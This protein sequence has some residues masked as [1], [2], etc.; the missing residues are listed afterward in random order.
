MTD[1]KPNLG[2]LDSSR[3]TRK[4]GAGL[5]LRPI[6]AHG[7]FPTG[8]GLWMGMLCALSLL[9]LRGAVLEQLVLD[10]D[11]D[12]VLPILSPPLGGLT[13]LMLAGA[14]GVVGA[15][16]GYALGR[17]LQRQGRAGARAEK[18]MSRTAEPAKSAKSAEP[19][20]RFAAM[21]A[22]MASL[23]T[24][25]VS[26]DGH[27]DAPA[28]AP[29]RAHEELGLSLGPVTAPAAAPVY[30]PASVYD[31]E[32]AHD[33]APAYDHAP[34]HQDVAHQQAPLVLDAADEYAAPEPSL[35]PVAEESAGAHPRL[36][37]APLAPP[38]SG[39]SAAQRIASAPVGDLNNVELVSRLAA[40]MDRHRLPA[41]EHSDAPPPPQQPAAMPGADAKSDLLDDA[42]AGLRA[43]G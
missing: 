13:R 4:A 2:L 42:L 11:L 20:G 17:A 37:P 12:S 7:L 27:P 16:L 8:T 25:L 41:G 18:P 33:H 30:D 31:H 14:L 38:T 10:Y 40:L 24:P 19:S 22:V 26:R 1:R 39:P 35:P 3:T 28:R 9:A 15:G 6:V 21:R 34:A 36:A 32:S 23:R 29:I 5:G 43:L